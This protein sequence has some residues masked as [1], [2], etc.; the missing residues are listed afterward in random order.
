MNNSSKSPFSLCLLVMA[1]IFI[2]VRYICAAIFVAGKNPD[3]ATFEAAVESTGPFL[4]ILSTVC[5]AGSV[6]VSA[7]DVYFAYRGRKKK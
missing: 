1:A 7:I 3:T 5:L 6:L 4:P 2:S